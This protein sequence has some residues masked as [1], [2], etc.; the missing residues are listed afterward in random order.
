MLSKP[1][2]LWIFALS[3]VNAFVLTGYQRNQSRN[4][5]SSPLLV[6]RATSPTDMSWIS[7]WA[8]IGDSFTAGIG[9]GSLYS[10]RKPDYE[11]SRYDYSY[12]AILNRYFGPAVKDFQFVACSGDKSVD[13]NNQVINMAVYD[14][15]NYIKGNLDLVVLTAGGNDLCLVSSP[16][17]TKKKY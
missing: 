17:A 12:P 9:S 11:C 13:I 15:I 2:S 7:R 8:A 1:W 16:S 5:E 4:V 6:K 14:Q 10:Q 3:V